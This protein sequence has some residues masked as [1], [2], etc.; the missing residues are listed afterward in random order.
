MEG[1]AA[2]ACQGDSG[3]P[4]TSGTSIGAIT[5]WAKGAGRTGCGSVTQGI[6]LGPQREWI[7]RTLRQWGRTA[8][9]DER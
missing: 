5:T 1:A 8:R 7:D 4:I 6:L 3:G 2:G 9:W